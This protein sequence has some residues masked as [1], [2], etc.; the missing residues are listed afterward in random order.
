MQKHV[1]VSYSGTDSKNKEKLAVPEE[2]PL[3]SQDDDFN[4]VFPQK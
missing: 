4:A 1:F 2:P 3:T